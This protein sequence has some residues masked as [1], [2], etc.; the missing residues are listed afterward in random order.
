MARLTKEESIEK[1]SLRHM[2]VSPLSTRIVLMI[3]RLIS[4][5]IHLFVMITGIIT[6]K[7]VFFIQ[8]TNITNIVSFVYFTL[9][10]TAS[11]RYHQLMKKQWGTKQEHKGK[12]RRRWRRNHSILSPET[13]EYIRKRPS[14]Q[15][16]LMRLSL[17]VAAT[18]HF[19][20]TAAFWSLVL[21]EFEVLVHPLLDWSYCVAA[22]GLT[23]ICIIGELLLSGVL[24]TRTAHWAV[25]ASVVV[26]GAFA[27]GIFHHTG[28]LVYAFCDYNDPI[29][30]I[31][32]GAILL[33]AAGFFELTIALTTL[34]SALADHADQKART[35]RKHLWRGIAT[36]AASA[37]AAL[38]A[39]GL[40]TATVGVKNHKAVTSTA[41]AI[42]GVSVGVGLYRRRRRGASGEEWS[43]DSREESSYD[44]SG[45]DK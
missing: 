33:L 7:S 6:R 8:L 30:Y 38:V 24:F 42:G 1:L 18:L 28:Y 36:S 27:I 10:A 32:F 40:R 35:A 37:A 16:E 17:A 43:V 15:A 23:L 13:I 3:W 34:R 22:H 14:L 20:V 9:A 25:Q 31:V 19:I 41:V 44:D 29:N 12:R 11:V 26:Y 45:E 5:S 4:F 2:S 21:Q 39:T